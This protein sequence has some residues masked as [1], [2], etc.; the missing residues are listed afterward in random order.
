MYED[1]IQTDAFINPGNS[2]GP[3]FDIDG[4]VMGMTTLINGIGRGL[5]FAIPSNMLNEVGP[6]LIATGHAT[7]PWIGIVVDTPEDGPSG[8]LVDQGVSVIS[9]ESGAPAF[10]SDLRARDIIA[11]VDGV[12]VLTAHD[13]QHEILRKKVGQT[14]DLTVLRAGKTFDIPVSTDELPADL[15]QVAQSHSKARTHP[16]DA[17]SY[18]LEFSPAHPGAQAEPVRDKMTGGV[19]VAS[20]DPDSPAGRADIRPGDILTAVDK[21]PVTDPGRCVELLTAHRG[22]TGPILYIT[23]AGRKASVVLDTDGDDKQ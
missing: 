12:P 22:A 2:G 6:E 21:E 1:Y 18:G 14:V 17:T 16:S 10:K 15:T 9:I 5:S 19:T 11:R 13:L 4:N 23:R 3:L 20:V 7:H 8:S